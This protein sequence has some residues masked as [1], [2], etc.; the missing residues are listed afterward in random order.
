MFVTIDMYTIFHAEFFGMVMIQE[1]EEKDTICL[2]PL[3]YLNVKKL[4]KT[5]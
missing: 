4:M 2:W 3:K 5:S 1:E